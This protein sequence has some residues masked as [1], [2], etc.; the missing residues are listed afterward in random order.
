MYYGEKDPKAVEKAAKEGDLMI[1][2]IEELEKKDPSLVTDVARRSAYEKETE[3]PRHTLGLHG[4]RCNDSCLLYRLH[5]HCTAGKE[6]SVRAVR[7]NAR[8]GAGYR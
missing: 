4:R 8:K 7:K 5:L 2:D 3:S 6:R 1:F